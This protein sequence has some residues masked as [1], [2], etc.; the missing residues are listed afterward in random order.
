MAQVRWSLQVAQDLEEICDYIGRDSPRYAALFAER[1]F[2]VVD[3]IAQ[4]PLAGGIVPEYARD[5]VRE[6]L[7]YNYR[8]IYRCRGGDAFQLVTLIHGA[9]ILPPL[10]E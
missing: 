3:L 2:E 6:R 7:I 9:R 10:S 1:V 5:D 8:L 4:F